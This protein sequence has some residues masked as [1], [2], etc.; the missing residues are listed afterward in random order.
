MGKTYR[1]KD[2]KN[3][4]FYYGDPETDTPEESKLA[5]IVYHSDKP[6]RWSGLESEV[7]ERQNEIARM[8]KR[9][10]KNRVLS[11]KEPMYDKTDKTVRQKANKCYQYS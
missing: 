2:I 1:R 4:G 8:E 11:G 5:D 10:I 9:K 3:N 6:K 7:K